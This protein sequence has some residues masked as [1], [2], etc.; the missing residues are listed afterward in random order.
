[1]FLRKEIW[2]KF[3]LQI[4]DLTD[5]QTHSEILRNRQYCLS[6]NASVVT[7]A[8]RLRVGSTKRAIAFG[9]DSLC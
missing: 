9:S 4:Y 5:L 8:Q 1:M 3:F 7:P 2:R 6:W